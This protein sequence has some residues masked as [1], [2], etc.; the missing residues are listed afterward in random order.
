MKTNVFKLVQKAILFLLMKIQP[1]LHGFMEDGSFEVR[2]DTTVY[3]RSQ[4]QT[5]SFIHDRMGT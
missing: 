4:S 1:G 3:S 2:A 5:L